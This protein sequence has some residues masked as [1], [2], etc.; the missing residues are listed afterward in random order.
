MYKLMVSITLC[1]L[2]DLVGLALAHQAGEDP[3]FSKTNKWAMYF[4][5][6]GIG[7]GLA[8]FIQVP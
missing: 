5:F 3:D 2:Q 1:T 4:A 7:T 6:L 8:F